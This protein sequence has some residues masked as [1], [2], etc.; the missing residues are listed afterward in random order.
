MADASS[1][2]MEAAAQQYQESLHKYQPPQD[3]PANS[4]PA[5]APPPPPPPPPTPSNADDEG[6]IIKQEHP[7]PSSEQAVPASLPLPPPSVTPDPSPS[8][9]LH[10]PGHSMPP[11]KRAHE[12]AAA[13]AAAAAAAA[14]AA[15]TP[16]PPMPTHCAPHGAPVRQYMNAKVTPTLL[17]A[18]K[19][20]AMEQPKDPLR[21]LGEYLLAKSKE[22]EGTE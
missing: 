3:A 6:S 17:E 11:R 7:L 5:A 2:S 12:A 13:T 21:F 19:E 10:Q 8:A 22:L 1:T 16:A 20:V 14:A 15:D 4:T 18:M 9:T